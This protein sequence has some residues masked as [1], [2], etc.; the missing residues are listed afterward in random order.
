MRR[1]HLAFA[2]F[3]AFSAGYAIAQQTAPPQP[4][5]PIAPPVAP[6]PIAPPVA[7]AQPAPPPP[8]AAPTAP[9]PPNVAANPDALP[10]L[11][12]GETD[13]SGADEVTL[14]AKKAA[15]IRGEMEW[16]GNYDRLKSLFNRL[17]DAIKRANLKQNGRAIVVFLE[18]D[19]DKFKYAAMIPIELTDGE[20]PNLGVGIAIED[21]PAGKAIRFAHKASYDEID[22]TYEIINAYLDQKGITVKDVIIEEYLIFGESSDDTAISVQIYVQPQ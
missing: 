16:D 18:S 7:P 1:F 6:A 2:G 5:A 21:T 17:N 14:V 11:A 3:L 15:T 9:A 8:V 19:D 12:P 10:T 20:K 13:P 4:P 22:G